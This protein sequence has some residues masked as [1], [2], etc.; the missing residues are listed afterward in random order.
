MHRC[1]GCMSAPLVWLLLQCKGYLHSHIHLLT[2]TVEAY[3]EALKSILVVLLVYAP[4]VVHSNSLHGH[5]QHQMC[6]SCCFRW[7]HHRR[8]Y[9]PGR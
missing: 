1:A 8:T 9:A 4:A 3:Q 7:Q 5:A 6:S 2:S